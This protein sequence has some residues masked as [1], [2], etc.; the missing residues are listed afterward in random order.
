MSKKISLVIG[1]AAI[2][3]LCSLNIRH[4]INNYGILA[5]TLS[6]KVLAQTDCGG[7]GG[8]GGCGGNGGGVCLQV[9]FSTR[10]DD[11]WFWVV[12]H[13]NR[14]GNELYCLIGDEENNECP[15]YD[16][17]HNVDLRYCP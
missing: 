16:M 8:D 17:K 5:N 13:C 9:F 7:N 15:P 6:A 1:L 10:I 11:C 3:L 4:A 14:G 2:I 12:F